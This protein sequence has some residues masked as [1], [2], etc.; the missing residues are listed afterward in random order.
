MSST[1]EHDDFYTADELAARW[2]CH[3]RYIYKLIDARVLLA[4]KLGPRVVRIAHKERERYEI[5]NR[6]SS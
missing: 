5:A 1:A 3:R 6:L 4:V 2:K